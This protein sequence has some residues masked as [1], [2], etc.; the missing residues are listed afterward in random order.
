MQIYA[1]NE[2]GQAIFAAQAEKQMDYHCLECQAIVRLRGGPYRQFH[3]YHVHAYQPCRLNGKSLAHLQVQ[4]T[5]LRQIPVEEG[6]MEVSFSS[7]H[8][9][10]DVAWF[11]E[12]IIFEI[13][14][15]PISAKEVLERNADYHK[16]GWQVIWV[17]HDQ[18]YNQARLTAAE[19]VMQTAPH[20]F[21]NIDEEGNGIIYDQFQVIQK[22]GRTH[23]LDPLPVQI[24]EVRRLNPLIQNQ[25]PSFFIRKR[26]KTWPYAFQGDLIDLS[27]SPNSDQDF[28]NYLQKIYLLETQYSLHTATLKE[29]ISSFFKWVLIRPYQLCFQLLLER[30][31][32]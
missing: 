19:W 1:L 16:L 31:C 13:Q 18:C 32:R 26:F 14:C 12:K 15:S 30:A 5:I 11:S 27:L 21:T 3:F 17:F 6:Q 8:R 7:I 25:N 24:K 28:K 4:E 2:K 10:A 9:I 23:R 20:Y 22:G 29:K